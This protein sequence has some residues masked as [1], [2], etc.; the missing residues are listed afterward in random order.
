METEN[1]FKKKKR[2][3]LKIM[4]RVLGILFV[5]FTI[6]TIYITRN[7]NQILAD[8]LMKSFNSS[9]VSDIYELKFD[10]LK[11]N[12]FNGN[13]R[14]VNV[15]LLPRE[16]PLQNYSYI[17]SSIHLTTKRIKLERVQIMDLVKTGKLKL[18]RIEIDK[19]DIEVHLN[20][21]V[22]KFLPYKDTVAT[23]DTKSSKNF[24]TAF[25]LDEFR[26]IDASFHIVNSF[27][28]RELSVQKLSIALST[29]KI[30]QQ[31]RMDFFSI[32]KVGLT[33]DEISGRMKSGGF[34]TLIL[35]DLSLNVMNLN[36]RNTVDTLIYTYADFNTGF[37]NLSMDTRDSVYNVSLQ[38]F[39][40]SRENSSI[41]IEKFAFQPNLSQA[42]LLKREKYQKAQFSVSAVSLKLLNVNFDTL[43]Y[44]QKVYIDEI[45]ID[46]VNVSLFKDKTKPVDRS[47]FPEYVGQLIAGI[48]IPLAVKKLTASAVNL[49]NVERKE[50]G[51]SARVVVD[52]GTLT[53]KNITN[54]DKD[55]LLTVNA[56]AY[57]ENK[58]FIKLAVAYSYKQPQFSL[59]VRS[60]S[61]NL[62]DLNHLLLAYTPAKISKG[63]VDG[64][65]L[66]GNVYR[67]S[68][69][70]T[71]KFLYHDLE[72]DMKLTDKKWQ[73]DVIAFAANTYLSTNNPP[74]A[75]IPPKVVKYN[76]E[77]DMNKGGF[78]VIIKSFLAG[79]KET[80]MM[81]K[82]NKQDYKEKKKAAR[83][84]KKANEGEKPKWNPLK[85]D[86]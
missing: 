38:S 53:A 5:I 39:G 51:K 11:V 16:K 73:N 28:E 41:S 36:A 55:G 7:F 33:I 30:D 77:R 82:E 8:A 70:G 81:S 24:L 42:E 83:A 44:R 23:A 78:N 62:L 65:T 22:H 12:I 26:L 47:R 63:V 61:F 50:D 74:S 32:N 10:K 27:N 13:I 75:G 4:W 35:N 58:V 66:S 79:M 43:I 86:R 31:T 15:T 57:I 14:V 69:T 29:I 9:V 68:A 46:T 1:G 59:D 3:G 21:A 84:E 34:R 72:V 25:S 20:G 76:V 71:M 45:Q 40:I 48:P 67:T 85:R 54:L 49:V 56:S 80:M 2:P 19:P 6:A 18:K 60:G 64:I 37:K 52:R 17:N